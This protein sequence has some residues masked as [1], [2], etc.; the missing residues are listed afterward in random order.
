MA[1]IRVAEGSRQH[2]GMRVGIAAVSAVVLLALPMLTD[3]VVTIETFT[4]IVCYAVAILGLSL[5]TGYTGQISIGMSAFVG[6][7]AYTTIILVETYDW[8]Y[9]ATIPVSIVFC[10]VAGAL[11]GIPALR[12]RGLYLVTVTLA[13][14]ALF[15][16]LVHKFSGLTGGTDGMF[17]TDMEVPTWTFVDPFVRTGPPRL[18]YYIIL[19]IAALA[20]L[21]AWNVVRSRIGRAMVAV[22]DSELSA[23]ANGVPVARVKVFAFALSAAYGGLAGSLLV[24]QSPVVSETRFDLFLS[25]FLLVGLIAGGSGTIVGAIPGAL[26]FVALRTYIADWSEALG[27]FGARAES[28]QIVGVISGLLLLAFVFLLPGGLVDGL[29][30]VR[31]RLVVITPRPPAGWETYLPAAPSSSP[32]P[33]EPPDGPPDGPLPRDG[34]PPPPDEPR[35]AAQLNG[36]TAPL[37]RTSR[38]KG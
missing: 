9:L 28:G 31:K 4:Q 17:A 10:L 24:I 34:E 5:L 26:V 29:S 11:V 32:P 20:F 12:I 38:E 30:K 18:H 21:V 16:V 13:V 19:V 6:L 3:S 14:A 8:A 23:L 36:T 15:P 2:R 25:V 33:A 35:L 1:P 22:R 27:L 37:Q 7:G